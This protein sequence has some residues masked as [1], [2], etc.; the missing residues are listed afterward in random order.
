MFN[1]Q[2]HYWSEY[3]FHFICISRRGSYAR[4]TRVP[5]LPFAQI[6][7]YNFHRLEELFSSHT[8]KPTH[9][10]HHEVS[11]IR[12]YRATK[13]EIVEMSGERAGWASVCYTAWERVVGVREGVG[14]R[15]YCRSLLILVMTEVGIEWWGNARRKHPIII[16]KWHWIIT[17]QVDYFAHL[18]EPVR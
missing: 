9:D 14:V 12:F 17:R 7:Q 6:C 1:T 15:R 5:Y 8:H 18:Q 2:L 3:L 16:I 13:R 10:I 4:T 11:D